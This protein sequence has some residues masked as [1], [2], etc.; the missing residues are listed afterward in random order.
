[1]DYVF[2]RIDDMLRGYT[3]EPSKGPPK[4][5][6]LYSLID[7]DRT[8]KNTVHSY[9]KVYTDLFC[10]RKNAKNVLEVGI[11]CGG[12]IKLWHDYFTNA[13]VYGL[14]IRHSSQVWDELKTLSRVKLLTSINAYD[15]DTFPFSEKKFDII[16]D[17]G[18]HKMEDMISFIKLYSECIADGGILII[19]DIPSIYW[20]DVLKQN[21]PD[22]LKP[23]VKVYNLIDTKNRFDDMLFTIDLSMKV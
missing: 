17:D 21:V 14:D 20:I 11:A 22:V 19:E 2:C 13:T 10:S 6:T 16:I 18:S 23:Y 1:M 4:P 15:A 9:L 7:N 3:P 5:L 8:D 12:S